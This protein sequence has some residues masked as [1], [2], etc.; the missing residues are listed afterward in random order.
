MGPVKH[1]YAELTYEL[2]EEHTVRVVDT[3]GGTT[4]VFAIGGR[5]LE[6]D[7]RHADIHFIRYVYDCREKIAAIAPAMRDS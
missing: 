7:I 2:T 6:G 3:V 4:G 1:P 5:W